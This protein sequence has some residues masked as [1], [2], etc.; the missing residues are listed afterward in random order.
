MPHDAAELLALRRTAIVRRRGWVPAASKTPA[1]RYKTPP[2]PTHRLCDAG[3]TD[4]LDIKARGM[5]WQLSEPG[6]P[7]M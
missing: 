7:D 2:S 5:V 3:Q 1:L 4:K 6:S